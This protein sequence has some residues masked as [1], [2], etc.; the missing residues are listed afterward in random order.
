MGFLAKVK[1]E[2]YGVTKMHPEIEV[3]VRRGVAVEGSA[4][5]PEFDQ[6]IRVV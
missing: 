3:F 2:R 1:L 4:V 6:R 5:D